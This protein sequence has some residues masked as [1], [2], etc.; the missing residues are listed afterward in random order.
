MA[1]SASASASASLPCFFSVQAR[2]PYLKPTRVP[3]FIKVQ[4]YQDE[5]RSTNMVDANLSVLNKRIEML[6]VKETLE[7]CCTTLHGWNYLPLSDHKTKLRNK[8]DLTLIEFTG[9]VCGTLALTCFGGTLFI[10]LL[11]LLAHLQL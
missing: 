8:E 1:A 5:E 11:S 4:N 2:G 9:L 3:Q 10:C 7:R 6:K